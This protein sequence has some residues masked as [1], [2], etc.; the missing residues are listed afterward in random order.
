MNEQALDQQV[1]FTASAPLVGKH[2]NLS[3]KGLPAST[4]TIFDANHAAYIDATGSGAYP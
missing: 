1:F 4:F 2:I 3:P